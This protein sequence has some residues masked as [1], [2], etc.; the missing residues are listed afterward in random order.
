MSQR[1]ATTNVGPRR[2][3]EG[4][5]DQ[6]SGIAVLMGDEPEVSDLDIQWRPDTNNLYHGINIIPEDHRSRDSFCYNLLS[7]YGTDGWTIQQCLHTVNVLERQDGQVF[8]FE[9]LKV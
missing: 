7:P 6:F 8:D 4:A 3:G 2:Y 9:S 5:P 1:A